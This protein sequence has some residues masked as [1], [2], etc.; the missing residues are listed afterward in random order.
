MNFVI[1][2]HTNKINGKCYIGLTSQKTY[3]RWKGGK[4]YVNNRYF[5]NAINKYGWN[6]FK[7][8]TLVKDIKTFELAKKLEKFYIKY[9]HSYIKD[10]KCNGYNLT[11]G[12]DGSLGHIVSE[13]TRRRLSQTTRK[14]Y[15]KEENRKRASDTTK[16]LWLDENYRLNNSIK[17]KE[18][19]KN[20][21]EMIE[22]KRNRKSM[23]GKHHK[24]ESKIK[25]SKTM[26]RLYEI[27]PE[28][29]AHL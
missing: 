26:K 4:G 11:K 16:K 29:D 20:H 17:H 8:E 13:K 21:P 23:L 1:Y 15:S 24:E 28:P 7:H 10:K 12:G 3:N 22:Q 25:M 18:Y 19:F 5:T 14:Y 2:K 9:Y 27:Y 6:N